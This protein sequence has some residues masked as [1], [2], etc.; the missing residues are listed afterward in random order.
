MTDGSLPAG[1]YRM[2]STEIL[3]DEVCRLGAID[4]H[5]FKQLARWREDVHY[6]SG[7]RL[8]VG[9]ADTIPWTDL[10]ET[11]DMWA[12]NHAQ[13]PSGLGTAAAGLP[14]H[15]IRLGGLIQP[16]GL[17]PPASSTGGT[18]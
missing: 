4:R 13:Q 15:P 6:L 3:V 18:P 11:L 1:A 7:N 17:L 8:I 12:H 2:G 14:A 5:A 10:S 9:H 16:S